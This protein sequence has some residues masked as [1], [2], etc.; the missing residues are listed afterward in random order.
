VDAVDHILLA[1]GYRQDRDWKTAAELY[2]K[3]YE[4]DPKAPGALYWLGYCY[5]REG[6]YDA[7]MQWLEKAR[8]A[9]PANPSVPALMARIALGFDL[10]DREKA[11]CDPV[12]ALELAEAAS[13]LAGGE[14]PGYLELV[15]R[16]QAMGGD[17]AAASKTV[18]RILKLVEEDADKAYYEKLEKELKGK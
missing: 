16:C 15:A 7:A 8:G 13:K 9:E 14:A 10:N 5:K 1:V 2:Q 18:K 3:A 17:K 4:L 11:K 12:K 6:D